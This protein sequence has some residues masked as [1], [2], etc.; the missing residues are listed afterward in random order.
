MLAVITCYPLLSCVFM[1]FINKFNNI[2]MLNNS[3]FSFD[4]SIQ[5]QIYG[6]RQMV[7]YFILRGREAENEQVGTC[8]VVVYGD[9]FRCDQ[10]CVCIAIIQSN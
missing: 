10:K 2:D 9:G 1:D 3:P 5:R 6:L 7:V 4:I 8:V